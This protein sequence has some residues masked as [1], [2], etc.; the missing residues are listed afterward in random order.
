MR[1]GVLKPDSFVVGNNF[2]AAAIGLCSP[3][4]AGTSGMSVPVPG[5]APRPGEMPLPP[6]AGSGF[7]LGLNKLPLRQVRPQ[8]PL[9]PRTGPWGA[10]GA[11]LLPGG[12]LTLEKGRGASFWSAGPSGGL[13]IA[14]SQGSAKTFISLLD[15]LLGGRTV[16]PNLLLKCFLNFFQNHKET[17]GWGSVEVQ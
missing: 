16:V 12:S 6:A 2:A 9:V 11:A 7:R 3:M 8:V 14:T 5:P 1:A 15:G 13:S 10:G 17:G 4:D